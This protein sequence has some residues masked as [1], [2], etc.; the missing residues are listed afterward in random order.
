MG[1]FK[2]NLL[3]LI[4]IVYALFGR[5]RGK[6]RGFSVELP[7]AVAWFVVCVSGYGLFWWTN[8]LLLNV[9]RLTG[10]SVGVIGTLLIALSAYLI[11]RQLRQSLRRWAEEE[12]RERSSQMGGV[13]GFVRT[14]VIFSTVVV[15]LSLLPVGFVDWPFVKGSFFLRHLLELAGNKID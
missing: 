8:H 13:T 4:P 6:R 2:F 9:G 5:W 1:F 15:T 14:A 3:D 11:V 12:Y 10:Q 7:S